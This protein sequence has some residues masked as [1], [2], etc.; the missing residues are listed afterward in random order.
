MSHA[1]SITD[2][3][4]V[5]LDRGVHMPD[6][7]QV[8]V[9]RSVNAEGIA[10]D[11]T[12]HPGVRLSGEETTIGPGCAL[13][14]EG[15]VVLDQCQLGHS[16][17]LKG[18]F[19]Q[20]AVFLDGSDMGSGAH[21]RPGTIVAEQA[22]GA[23]TVGLKQTV[24]LPFVTLGSLINFCD[25]LMSGGTSRK[26]HSE[27]GSSYI[28]FN[29]TPH[30]DKATPSLI[31]DVPR[32]V[33]LDQPPIFLGGQGGLVG[34][35]RVEFGVVVAAGV[36]LRKD[37]LQP[38]CVYTGDQNAR[39]RHEPRLYDPVCYGAIDRLVRNNLIYIGNLRALQLWYRSV[40]YRM[41]HR[42]PYR[43]SCR[44]GALRQLDVIVKERIKRLGD[45][46]DK[47]TASLK[48][49]K[50]TASSDDPRM[51]QQQRLQDQWPAMKEALKLS[52]EQ[53]DRD[54][55]EKEKFM[56]AWEQTSPDTFID[57]LATLSPAARRAGSVWLQAMV[58]QTVAVWD[59]D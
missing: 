51:R 1:D 30:Q 50:K 2:T 48:A 28:H 11:V 54:S 55:P 16:V 45:V 59:H 10:P 41:M 22:G 53:V 15:P 4:K 32:G 40:R 27:V 46:A 8:F 18:G 57:S 39:G 12:L 31:G 3:V 37:A 36:V 49:L 14:A 20:G 24:L 42:D 34:P 52:A 38:G 5:L 25:C 7:H 26:N 29:F 17:S 21:V 35:T 9:D 47:M 6:P 43:E 23:H 19:F 44:L 58:D 56:H 13:G 33:M